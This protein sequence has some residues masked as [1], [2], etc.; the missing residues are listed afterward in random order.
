M[1]QTEFRCQFHE[2]VAH[3][4]KTISDFK[5]IANQS[6]RLDRKQELWRFSQM[7]ESRAHK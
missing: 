3:A 6:H 5:P 1:G 7:K 4:A 2:S